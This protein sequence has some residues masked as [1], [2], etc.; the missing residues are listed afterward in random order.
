MNAEKASPEL[1]LHLDKPRKACFNLYAINRLEQYYEETVGESQL[2]KAIDWRNMNM[3]TA[4][5]LLWAMLL[6]DDPALTYEQVEKLG[7][8]YGLIDSLPE[9]MKL[10]NSLVERAAPL[11]EDE[12]LQAAIGEYEKKTK[13]ITQKAEAQKTA[14]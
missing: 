5:R 10:L 7:D 11:M 14:E 6:N 1:V 13:A 2:W 3:R 8:A 12:E 4:T 9:L